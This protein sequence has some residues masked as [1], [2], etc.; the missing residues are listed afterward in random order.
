MNFPNR[1]GPGHVQVELGTAQRWFI[2]ILVGVIVTAGGVVA[3]ASLDW[4]TR[5]DERASAQSTQLVAANTQ[6]AAISAQLAP[7]AEMQRQI[8]TLSGDVSRLKDDVKEMQ[9]RRGR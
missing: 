3:K 2:G 7:I 6:L 1:R 5:M 9:G 8:G 4:A